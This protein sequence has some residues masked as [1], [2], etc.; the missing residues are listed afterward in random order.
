MYKK[1][2]FIFFSFF[3]D[4]VTSIIINCQLSIINYQLSKSYL[5]TERIGALDGETAALITIYQRG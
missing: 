1:C 4:L 3:R 2:F 5:H